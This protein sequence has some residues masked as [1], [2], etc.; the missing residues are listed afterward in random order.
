M[1]RRG[2]RRKAIRLRSRV[3]WGNPG[4]RVKSRQVARDRSPLQLCASA[5]G[6]DRWRAGVE[7][8][9]S[10]ASG[11]EIFGATVS[12]RLLEIVEEGFEQ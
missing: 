5:T 4:L 11:G 3:A 1:F 6:A 8:W 7:A 9:R 10:P 2:Y 12:G